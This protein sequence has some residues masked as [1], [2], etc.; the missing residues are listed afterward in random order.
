MLHVTYPDALP[1]AQFNFSQVEGYMTSLGREVRFA[2][3]PAG[4][5]KV[6]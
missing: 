3:P 2:L 5:A 1:V 6:S 4:D